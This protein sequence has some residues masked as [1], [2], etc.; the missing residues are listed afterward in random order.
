MV[1]I[2]NS[3][4]STEQWL[5][6][7]ESRFSTEEAAK[8]RKAVELVGPIYA[9]QT[10]YP[11]KVDLLVHS[12]RCAA[13][14]AEMNL[15]ADAVI[16]A[17][18]YALPRFR[19]DWT[20]LLNGFGDKVVELVDG[21]SKVTQIR[22]VSDLELSQS[23]NEKAEQVE[24]MRKM[25]LAMVSDIRVVILVLVGRSELM[26]NLGSC[27]NLELEQKIAEETLSIF[28]PLANRLGVWQIKWELEDL[29][30][31]YLYPEQYKKV[32]ELLDETRE[33]RVS[34]IDDIKSFLEQEMKNSDITKFQVMGRA[35]HL[36]SIWMKMKK[37]NYSF[38][39]L[40]DIRAVRILVPEIRDC[41]TILGIVHTKYSPIPGEFDDYISNPK[42]NNYQ[43]IH[44]C[45][46]G[47]DGKVVEVQIR[48]FAMHEHAEYGVAAH[49]RYKE[50]GD[51]NKNFEEK[52]SWIRHILEWRDEN[53]SH[54]ELSNI[55]KNEIF[56][57]VIYVLTP[58][59]RVISLPKGSTPIDFAYA[60]HSS[61]GH[62]C[63]GAKVDGQIVTLGTELKNGQRIEVLTV[64]EGGPSINW[65][66]DGL[67]RSSKAIAHVR[68]WI[69]DQNNETFL[70]VGNEIFTRELS[71]FIAAVRPKNEDIVTKLGYV[72]EKALIVDLGRDELPL[73]KLRLTIEELANKD[74]IVQITKETKNANEDQSTIDLIKGKSNTQPKGIG[75]GSVLVDGVSGIVTHVAKCCKPLPGDDVV[76]FISS[77]NGIS[78]HRA[79][80]I[81]LKRQAKL[82]PDKLVTITFGK[83][84]NSVF[85]VDIEIIAHD[86]QGLIRDL[87]ALLVIEK[88]NI[89][90]IQ[91]RNKN[92]KAIIVFTLDIKEEFNINTLLAKV[93]RVESVISVTRR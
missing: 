71:K 88:L 83:V 63:R 22:R 85:N 39:D 64:K 82:F 72:N 79:N 33:N 67:V 12:V 38:D 62:R 25:L 15:L 66:H 5:K 52:I 74:K 1:T 31:K 11:T 8:I 73:S 89:S 65:L 91:T 70:E 93:E 44:T 13:K 47:P 40:Y 27:H 76:G 75:S 59:G 26:L 6:L 20:L 28:A 19:D 69:R 18:C 42:P 49:W 36:Y 60:V 10:F 57:D 53:Q 56:S 55:F 68:R 37:K 23:E 51:G 84:G 41:Y 34:Y 78:I 16:G 29:S 50:G 90:G 43:S 58:N 61:I 48:T 92:D 46:A 24:I 3:Y 7:C 86:R 14:I 35:K 54:N 9:N 4:A 77:V 32:A 87:T 81:G 17:L 2:K 21:V 80:C 45:V 30:F